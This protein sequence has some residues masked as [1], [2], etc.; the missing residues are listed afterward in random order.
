MVHNL[1]P[2]LD[3]IFLKHTFMLPTHFLS[4]MFKLS[5]N[6]CIFV[7]VCTFNWK[8][9]GNKKI[10]SYNCV[11]LLCYVMLLALE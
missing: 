4:F 1:E 2:Q 10:L 6:C 7:L 5:L 9:C 3:E 11:P 8:S